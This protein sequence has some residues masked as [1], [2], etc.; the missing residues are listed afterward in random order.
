MYD[1]TLP[2]VEE[3]FDIVLVS[4][5]SADEVNGSTPASGASINPSGQVGFMLKNHLDSVYC[6]SRNS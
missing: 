6:K 2:E 4:A 5:V 1:D 3:A